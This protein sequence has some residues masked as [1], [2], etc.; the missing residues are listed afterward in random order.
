MARQKQPLSNI[1]ELGHGSIIQFD[2]SYDQPLV[3]EAGNRAIAE[4]EAVKVGD[5]FGIRLTSIVLPDERFW[6]VRPDGP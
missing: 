2:K 4:G 1:F 6:T 3:L 5:K